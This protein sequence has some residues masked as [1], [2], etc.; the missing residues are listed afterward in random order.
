MATFNATH[1]GGGTAGHPSGVAKAYVMTSPVYDAVDN[2]DLSQGDIVQ[3]MDIPADTM[4][5]GGCIE[6][7]EASGNGQITFDLGFT[8]GDVDCLIDGGAS[9]AVITPFLSAAAGATASSPVLLTAA[10]TIDM[11]VIDAGSSH[12]AAWRFRAHVVL[13]DV[14]KNPVESATVSTGT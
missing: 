3:I 10:D 6:T 1:S 7:L 13:V 4:I 11:L 5:V 8:G 12:S 14:S 2:T 9:T